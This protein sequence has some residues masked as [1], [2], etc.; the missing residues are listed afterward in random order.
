LAVTLVKEVAMKSKELKQAL[1]VL[2]EV[3]A[4]PSLEPGQLNRLRVAKRELT[5]L[6]HGGKLERQRVFRAVALV[7][8]VMCERQVASTVK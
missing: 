3:L 6:A 1:D 8:E 5:A 7:A 4:D 2:S